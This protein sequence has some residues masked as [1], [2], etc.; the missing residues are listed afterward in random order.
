MRGTAFGRT[1]NNNL[2]LIGAFALWVD[3]LRVHL[4]RRE[5]R[6]IAFLGIRG[7]CHRPYVAGS[8]WPNSDEPRALN[9]VRA[10]VL[11]VRRA[12]PDVLDIEGSTLSLQPSVEVDLVDLI[13]CAEQVVRDDGCDA[14]RAEQLLGTGDLLP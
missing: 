11:K 9:S 2:H 10:A 6:L 3:G 4:G 14:E 12:A 13:E 5:E 1:Q 7:S 8:L